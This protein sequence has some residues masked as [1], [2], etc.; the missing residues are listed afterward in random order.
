MALKIDPIT[1]LEGHWG[2]EVEISGS[3]VVD[4]NVKGTMFRG[5]EIILN[6]RNP[7]DATFI[8]QRICGVCPTTHGMASCK[9][10]ENTFGIDGDVRANNNA[11]NLRNLI[12]GAD[13]VMSHITHFYHLAAADFINFSGSLLDQSGTVMSPWGPQYTDSNMVSGA[14]ANEL[15]GHYVSA[16]EIRRKVHAASALFSGRHPIQAA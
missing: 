10:V 16:L 5:F 9:C 4:A 14:T 12:D 2:I 7:R 3:T 13:L 1:R 6:G 8:T 11:R 15:I